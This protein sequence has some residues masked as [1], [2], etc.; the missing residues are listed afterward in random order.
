MLQE[1][2]CRMRR[3]TDCY[4]SDL[5]ASLTHGV[6]QHNIRCHV[7]GQTDSGRQLFI[8]FTVRDKQIRVISARNM[9]RKE[10]EAYAKAT[11]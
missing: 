8:A 6:Y 5:I 2:M 11:T 7:L 10:S 9:S 3:N 4:A 1:Q